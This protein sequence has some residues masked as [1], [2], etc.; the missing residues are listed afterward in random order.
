MNV[1]GKERLERL[2]RRLKKNYPDADFRFTDESLVMDNHKLPKYR[3][4]YYIH[5]NQMC[6][7]I[8]GWDSYG[9]SEGFLEFYCGGEPEGFITERRAYNLFKGQMEASE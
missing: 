4:A 8:W 9:F 1:D 5:G 7:A 6:Y 3:V 2:Y